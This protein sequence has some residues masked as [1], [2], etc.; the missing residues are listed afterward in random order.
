MELRQL[1]YFVNAATT[2]SF[3]EASRLSNITQST[4]S[5]QIKQLESELGVQLFHR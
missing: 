5:Q 2:L 4:L 1:R 3:T